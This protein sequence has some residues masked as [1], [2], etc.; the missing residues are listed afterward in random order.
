M[1]KQKLP[2]HLNLGLSRCSS[3][4]GSDHL[5]LH[6]ARRGPL[7]PGGDPV[8]QVQ[9]GARLAHAKIPVFIIAS[10]TA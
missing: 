6:P 8:L 9:E 4:G 10:C 1:V 2:D 5:P 3:G 7:R